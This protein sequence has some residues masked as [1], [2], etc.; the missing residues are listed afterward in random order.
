[1]AQAKVIVKLKSDS[2][3]IKVTTWAQSIEAAIEAV[4]SAQNAPKNAVVYAKVAPLTIYDIKQLSESTAPEFF[5]RRTMRFFRQKMSDFSV[6]RCGNDKF[7]I[8]APFGP[9]MGNGVTKRIFNPF[10]KE[11]ERL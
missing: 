4:C 10:T 1:M 11:L 8:S 6:T 7:M 3:V 2:G 9:G 5:T